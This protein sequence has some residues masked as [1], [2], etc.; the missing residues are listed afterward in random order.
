MQALQKTYESTSEVRCSCDL[1]GSE[2]EDI[3]DL[4]ID[5]HTGVTRCDTCETVVCALQAGITD[6]IKRKLR[7]LLAGL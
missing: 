3:S 5:L 1:C 7:K 6:E 2:A 4:N